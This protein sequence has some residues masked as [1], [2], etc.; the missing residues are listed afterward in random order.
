MTVKSVQGSQVYLDWIRTSGSFGLV[1]QS[2][3]FFWRVKLRPPPL[4]VRWERRDS[5]LD[6][7]G[8]WT[9]SGD[10]EGKLGLFLSCGGTLGVPLKW[11][12]LRRG[13]A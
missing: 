1:A 10:K 6:E 11:R 12:R 8:K 3:E 5:L 7:A 9:L 2:L 13:T 4:E